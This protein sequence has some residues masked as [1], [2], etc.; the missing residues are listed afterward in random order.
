MSAE[1]SLLEECRVSAV[2]VHNEG[3]TGSVTARRPRLQPDR[4][5]RCRCGRWR[6]SRVRRCWV[7]LA[8]PPPLVRSPPCTCSTHPS[9]PLT[10]NPRTVRRQSLWRTA[11]SRTCLAV[12]YT[13]A[14]VLKVCR[15]RCSWPQER[16]FGAASCSDVP[17]SALRSVQSSVKITARGRL[18]RRSH[19]HRFTGERI[20]DSLLQRHGVPLRPSFRPRVVVGD[21]CKWSLNRSRTWRSL[22]DRRPELPETEH[23]SLP[24]SFAARKVSP[25]AAATAASSCD[26]QDT[27][28]RL[29]SCS[30]PF[31]KLV[32]SGGL[33]LINLPSEER[34]RP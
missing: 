22:R 29:P 3:W 19:S 21:P 17:L 28:S 4:R 25:F 11:R 6:R 34:E 16:R 30:R 13:A 24:K 18:A 26:L 10:A 23:R 31:I 7:R 14:L 20:G 1:R 2:E 27:I 5:S 32:R 33:G 12:G 15:V 8:P 9:K